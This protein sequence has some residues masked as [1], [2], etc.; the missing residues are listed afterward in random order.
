MGQK[1]L[2]FH[3]FTGGPV[4]LLD[5]VSLA[6]IPHCWAFQLR[7]P[8]LGPVYLPYPRSL[9]LSRGSPTLYSGSCIFPFILL[10]FWA[11]FL[12]P[13]TPGPAPIFNSPSLIPPW[14]LPSSE[15]RDYFVFPSKCAWSIL[16]W[17]FLFVWLLRVCG[18]Y[19][20]FSVLFGWTLIMNGCLIL[21]KAFFISHEMI[22]WF[23]LPVYLCGGLCLLDFVC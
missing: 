5:M 13:L 21:S 6:S 9:E 11:S 17:A 12:S 3:P 14:S 22:M 4:W 8:T 10:G 20:G 16:T 18:L 2:M 15:L 23:C 7:S 19:H 1:L